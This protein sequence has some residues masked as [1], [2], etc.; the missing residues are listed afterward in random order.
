MR[1]EKPASHV[2]NTYDWGCMANLSIEEVGEG[3]VLSVK[4]VPGASRTA[5]SGLHGDMLKVRVSAAPEKGK[6]NK[7]LC[8]CLAQVL[9]VKKK[10]VSVVSGQTSPAKR[11]E[12]LGIS[13]ETVIE[14]LG[15]GKLGGV[16]VG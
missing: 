14:R 12:V 8:E 10:A 9:G 6:A 2:R 13:K 4:V 16:D 15:P 5:V 7:C 11:V 3:V 1:I